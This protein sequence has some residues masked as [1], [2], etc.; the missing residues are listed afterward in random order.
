MSALM[1]ETNRKN[2]VDPTVFPMRRQNTGNQTPAKAS[3]RA[4]QLTASLGPFVACPGPLCQ[5]RRSCQNPAPR[6][7]MHR[8]PMLLLKSI[9]Q[10]P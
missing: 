8:R 10:D 9:L 4:A 6:K 3:T 5:L 7:S 2:C 1:P